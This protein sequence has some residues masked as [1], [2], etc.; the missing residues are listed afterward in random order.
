MPDSC[1]NC[2]ELTE[3]PLTITSRPA[4]AEQAAP[5]R[6]YSMPMARLPSKRMR[7]ASALVST[8]TFRRFIAG[9]RNARAADMRRPFFV[10]I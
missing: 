3:P 4:R 6:T 7:V 1:S 5:L 8:R 10:E 2:G 9:R